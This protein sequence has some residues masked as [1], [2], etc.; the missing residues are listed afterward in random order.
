MNDIIAILKSKTIYNKRNKAN[1]N[2]I[3]L[4]ESQLSVC[5][6]VDYKLYLKEY[7]YIVYDGHELTGFCKVKRLNVVDVTLEEQ[8]I[9][10]LVPTDW[11]VIEQ[12]H[13]DGI[14]IWQTSTGEIYQTAPAAKPKKICD[15]L[16]EYIM[17]D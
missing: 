14:V 8:S 7:G 11:Y 4:M 13:I 16:A 6:S 15:S 12:L 5:F 17:L 9:N 1:E 2:D 10:P 3:S